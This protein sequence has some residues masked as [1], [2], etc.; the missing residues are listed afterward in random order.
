M[1]KTAGVLHFTIP[2]K[3]L[4]RSERFY[5]EILGLTKVRRNSHMVFMRDQD[6]Y[7]V[8]TQSENP[9]EPNRGDKHDIHS[10]FKISPAEYEGHRDL[11]RGGPPSRYLPGQKRL[12][13][14]SRSQRDRADVA[15]RAAAVGGRREGPR[16]RF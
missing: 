11:Q 15:V 5:T 10:A 4:D 13:P 14:R 2:V 7:F 9:I 6:D 3:D 8:L 1:I 16:V 12:L